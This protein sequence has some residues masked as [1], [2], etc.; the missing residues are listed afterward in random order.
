[1][2]GNHEHVPSKIRTFESFSQFLNDSEIML[3]LGNLGYFNKNDKD[4][5]NS[6]V[7]FDDNFYTMW[8]H[9]GNAIYRNTQQVVSIKE[10]EKYLSEHLE[11]AAD[12][13]LRIVREVSLDSILSKELL[14]KIETKKKEIKK[15][16]SEAKKIEQTRKEKQ[17]A[18]DLEKARKILKAA[19]E[20]K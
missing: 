11:Y 3:E 19:G 5:L 17:K 15:K 14:E 1:V 7:K 12:N 16:Q 8:D 18:K 13:R 2:I 20:I 6:K 10:L 4:L 9:Y